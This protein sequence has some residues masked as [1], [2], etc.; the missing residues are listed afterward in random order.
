MFRT[1]SALVAGGSS[2]RQIIPGRNFNVNLILGHIPSLNRLMT[3]FCS[4]A[5]PLGNSGSS[6]I[7]VKQKNEIENVF[8]SGSL[9][10][11]EH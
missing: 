5:G 7:R 1:R 2:Y 10:F 8:S 3:L 4:L 9:S 6:E 11:T